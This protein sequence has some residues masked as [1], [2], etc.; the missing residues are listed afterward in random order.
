MGFTLSGVPQ[1]GRRYIELQLENK[2]TATLRIIDDVLKLERVQDQLLLLLYCIPGRIQHLLAAIPMDIS[3]PFARR[4]DEALR[5]A[6]AQVLQLGQLTQRHLTD[7]KEGFESR[8]GTSGLRSIE[9]NH[10][11]L[12]LSGFARS[13]RTIQKSFPH[14]IVAR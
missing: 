5:N 9:S 11:F 1:G 3:M 10:E 2:L 13:I 14:S 4:H 7:A 8:N 12:F 6:V